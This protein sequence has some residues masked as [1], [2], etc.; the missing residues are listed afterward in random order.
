MGADLDAMLLGQAHGLAH[1]VE[2]GA[3]E[4][5]GYVGDVDQGHQAFIVAHLVEAEGFSHVAVDVDHLSLSSRQPLWQHSQNSDRPN[6]TPAGCNRS[7]FQRSTNVTRSA[8][9]GKPRRRRQL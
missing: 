1:V 7:S 6:E 2:V 5:A 9:V 8:A 4:S 3:M